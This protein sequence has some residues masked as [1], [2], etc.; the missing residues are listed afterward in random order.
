MIARVPAS[1]A[2]LGPGFDTLA[3]ALSMYIEVEAEPCD[4]FEVEAQGEGADLPVSEDHLGAK[5]ARH[6]LGH[7]NMR[8]RVRS[9]I[10]LGRGLGSSA[11]F[12]AACAAALGSSDPFSVASLF[13]GHPENAAASVFG[14]FVSATTIDSKYISNSFQVDPD[15]AVV[16]VIPE[17]VLATKTAR[18]VLPEVVSFSDA[19]FNLGRMGLLMAGLSDMD[20]LV[21]QA[22]EDRLHQR[23]RSSLYPESAEIMESLKSAGCV[24]SSWSGAGP[25]MIG[26]CRSADAKRIA[27]TVA[28]LLSSLDLRAVVR[29][30]TVDM[31]G[32]VVADA[33]GPGFQPL[34]VASLL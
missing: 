17:A 10:P 19:T 27:Q 3:L 14:G 15:L 2:N 28:G 25:T 1:S 9:Q 29:E 4:G 8:L 5:V 32:L 13:D 20:V 34:E 31:E 22:T 30:L 21:G 16:V 33:F 24:A 18:G 7:S 23:Y 26:F 11:A 12:A 6:V